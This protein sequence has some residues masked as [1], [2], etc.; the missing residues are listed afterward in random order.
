MLNEAEAKDKG[1]SVIS[2]TTILDSWC[3]RLIHEALSGAAGAR[4][5]G[6][7][8]TGHSGR[9]VRVTTQLP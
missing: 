7:R 3:V 2:D 4:S 5:Q 1:W 9:G 8:I 6:A